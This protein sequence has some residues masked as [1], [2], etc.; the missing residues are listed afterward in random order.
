[1]HQ[2]LKWVD[3]AKGM[4]I[5]FVVIGH[6]ESSTVI[7]HYLFWF[8]MPLFFIISGFLYNAY[9]SSN[10]L[11]WSIKISKRFI[12][13]YISYGL[14]ISFLVLII[15]RD[16]MDFL[17]QLIKLIYGG[18][19]LSG[20]FAT[21]WFITCLL[22]TQIIFAIIQSK[23]KFRTQ[24]III[25]IFYLLSQMISNVQFLKNIPFPSNLDVVL[26]S[27]CYY[28]IGFY[29][30]SL[31]YTLCNRISTFIVS[32]IGI[33]IF[34]IL[35]ANNLISYNLDMKHNIYNHIVLDL[36]IPV[37]CTLFIF[38]SSNL[39]SKTPFASIFERC[40]IISL[41]IM[42]LHMPINLLLKESLSVHYGIV[43]F[44]II[45]IILPLLINKF[46]IEKNH[47]TRHFL[48]GQ[49]NNRELDK[50]QLKVSI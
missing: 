24:L 50:N 20:S 43:L 6:S 25:F 46:I 19:M 32:F 5:I 12:I 11:N 9:Y 1:M 48:L 16:P 33:I 21:F 13:P 22:F 23:F 8:H 30:K 17:K 38:C 44:S 42:Y 29:G 49:F 18:E 41:T 10:L 47:F 15:H 2:R 4:G 36:L 31:I 37:V 40:G 14:L 35:D 45:G 3:I 34:V 27:I 26:I 28:S 39:I 7:P